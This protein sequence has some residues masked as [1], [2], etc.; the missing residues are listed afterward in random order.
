M[1]TAFFAPISLIALTACTHTPDN[2]PAAA[3]ASAQARTGAVAIN[4]DWK[5][6][7]PGVRR[8][9]RA[10]DLPAPSIPADATSAVVTMAA[11]AGAVLP[12]SWKAGAMWW[13][14]TPAARRSVSP[15][16]F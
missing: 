14:C 11:P 10:S 4:D 3:G 12:R 2:D 16:R 8:L 1:R 7:G 5:S 15:A 9:I 6:D 13:H